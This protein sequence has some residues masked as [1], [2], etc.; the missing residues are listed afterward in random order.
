MNQANAKAQ[1][2]IAAKEALLVA[3]AMKIQELQ[4]MLAATSDNMTE[5]QAKFAASEKLIA[6][7]K[8]QVMIQMDE[9]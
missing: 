4:K 9:R 5:R 2:S 3:A 1:A 8:A 7:L 6:L